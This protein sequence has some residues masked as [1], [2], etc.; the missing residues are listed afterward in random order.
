MN[1]NLLIACLLLFS[2][3]AAAQSSHQEQLIKNT[4][5]LSHT[6]FGTKDS[7][8]LER[9][10]APQLSY[11][12]SRGKVESR[13]EALRGIIDNRSV[14]NDTAVSDI[15][16]IVEHKTAIVRHRFVATEVKQD[17]S[18]AALNFTMILVWVR[19]GGKWQLLARQAVVIP[20]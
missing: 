6:V 8:V 7:A 16:L 17:G 13:A 4:Y 15:K 1:M 20:K 19:K 3:Q 12:H 10:F 2:M 18:T 11:G 5:V 9:L 14:Y